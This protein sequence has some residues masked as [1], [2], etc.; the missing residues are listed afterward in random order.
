VPT[1]DDFFVQLVT[2]QIGFRLSPGASSQARSR[3]LQLIQDEGHAFAVT[4]ESRLSN[5]VTDHVR[6]RISRYTAD[7]VSERGPRSLAFPNDIFDAGL[8]EIEVESVRL[9][10]WEQSQFANQIATA[11]QANRVGDATFHADADA[12][13]RESTLEELRLA[14]QHRQNVQKALSDNA[15]AD[16]ELE[17]WLT[18]ADRLDVDPVA[19]AMP[20]Q[21]AQANANNRVLAEKLLESPQFYPL[22]RQRPDL[23]RSLETRL[24]RAGSFTDRQ[25]LVLDHLNPQRAL[26]APGQKPLSPAD[27]RSR[28]RVDGFV[29]DP[30]ILRSWQQAAGDPD[31]IVGAASAARG[32]R[33]ILLLCVQTPVALSA[34][35]TASLEKI[36]RQ[37]HSSASK[38]AIFALSCSSIL[39]FFQACVATICEDHD[40]RTDV[41]FRDAAGRGEV[42]VNL[43]GDR[44]KAQVAHGRLTSPT[45]PVVPAI[46]ALFGPNVRVRFSI[47]GRGG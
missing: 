18:H 39:S 45:L 30:D 44:A 12:I 20:D 26:S 37:K 5:A 22:L 23:L 6:V 1:A 13:K 38:Y 34:K 25:N 36:L 16:L 14:A 35:Q 41:S 10:G 24:S 42:L 21:W 4:L 15:V 29:I 11:R 7:Q 47:N 27:I 8:P 19:L 9:I 2:V 32:N 3:I 28:T 43:V 17:R 31:V 46:E 33:A 40:L